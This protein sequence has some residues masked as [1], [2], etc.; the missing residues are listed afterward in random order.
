MNSVFVLRSESD[1]TNNGLSSKK[2]YF[3]MITEEDESTL[4]T[5]YPEEYLVLVKRILWGE[6]AWYLRPLKILKPNNSL[7]PMFGGNYGKLDYRL[8]KYPLPIHDRYET[9]E[10]Y[11]ALSR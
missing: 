2:W 5:D 11:D 10:E 7:E 8:S 1:C 3:R 9:Q 4:K 6:K